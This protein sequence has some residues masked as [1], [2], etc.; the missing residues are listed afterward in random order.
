MTVTTR[1]SFGRWLAP[2][3]AVLLAV[4][5]GSVISAV[6]ATARDSLAPRTAQQ[7]LVDVQ[8]A[9][10]DGLSGTV[11]ETSNLGLPPLPGLGGGESD[12]SSM[13]SGTHTLKV[14]Y[15]GPEQVRVALLGRLGE[16]DLI[17]NGSDLWTWASSDKSVT[18]RSLP[19]V[20]DA[21]TSSDT[22][23]PEGPALT[24]QQ[25]ADKAIAAITPS[26]QV[27]TDPTAVVAGR[28]A[29]QLVL[30][31]QDPGT[32]VGSVRIAIDGA[33]H[34]PTRVQ[35]YAAGASTPALEVGFT[36]FDPTT[37]P[38]S[39]FDFQ[40]SADATV[41]EEPAGPTGAGASP[42]AGFGSLLTGTSRPTVVGQDWT[43]VIVASLPSPGGSGNP[44]DAMLSTLPAVSGTWGSGRLLRGALFSV[45]VTDDARIAVGAV[46]PQLLYDALAAP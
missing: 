2:V 16:S 42:P 15:A 45:V 3:V 43:S 6:R 24:P 23:S 17:R 39:V 36:S 14:W 11:S 34:I 32:L 25:L 27:T 10:V 44:L 1:R 4:S 12:F 5:A 13:I 46:E 22:H 8:Q 31:P 28:P 29:Y 33:T 26:T 9:R 18:H 41:T 37:P 20:S 38:A 35:V 30:T 40:P 7:L 21:P 19:T